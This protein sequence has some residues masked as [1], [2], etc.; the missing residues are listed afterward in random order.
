MKLPTSEDWERD[1][2]NERWRN[3][4]AAVMFMLIVAAILW[5]LVTVTAGADGGCVNCGWW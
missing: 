4:Q 1:K 2:R 3:L 5:F